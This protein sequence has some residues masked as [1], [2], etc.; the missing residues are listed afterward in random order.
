LPDGQVSE[1]IPGTL[2]AKE[3][4]GILDFHFQGSHPELSFRLHDVYGE[5]LGRKVVLRL[6]QL[7]P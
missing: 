7:Q 3:N 4:F 6:D 2:A 1:R 5:P